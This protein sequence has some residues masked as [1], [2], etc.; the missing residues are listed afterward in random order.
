MEKLVQNK[1][2]VVVLIIGCVALFTLN[3]LFMNT[4]DIYSEKSDGFHLKKIRRYNGQFTQGNLSCY[5]GVPCLP[6]IAEGVF[7]KQAYPNTII[8][9]VKKCGTRALLSILG[10]HPQVSHLGAEAHY[11][12]YQQ[13]YNLGDNWYKSRMPFEPK[14]IIMEKSPNYAFSELTPERL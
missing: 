12:D 1:N 11:F 4:S 7:I 3:L 13:N 5:P 6:S 2:V 10:S 14:K 8:I 9:G